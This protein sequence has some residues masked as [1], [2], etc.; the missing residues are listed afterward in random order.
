M[1]KGIPGVCRILLATILTVALITTMFGITPGAAYAAA[2]V[3]TLDSD[4][5]DWTGQMYITDPT[6]DATDGD[7][8]ITAFYWA[9]NPDDEMCYWMIARVNSTKNV[10]YQVQFDANNDGDFADHVDRLVEVDYKPMNDDSKVTVTVLYADNG[11]KISETNNNDWGESKNEGASKVEF[12]A[13]FEDLGISIGQTIRMYGISYIGKCYGGDVY[14]N[15][16]DEGDEGDEDDEDEDDPGLRGES[17]NSCHISDRVPDSGDV[18]WAPVPVLGYPLLV[19]V[20][21]LGGTA[22]WYFTG[23]RRWSSL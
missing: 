7:K 22:I 20:M 14:R 17:K 8:D 10:N 19:A 12:G 4:F 18:Q 15:E 9:N 16:G 2:P 11:R 1:R 5:S 21:M 13:S 23:R 3:I 6:G